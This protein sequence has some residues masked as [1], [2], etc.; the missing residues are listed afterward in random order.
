[1]QDVM[2]MDIPICDVVFMTQKC[3]VMINDVYTYV[4]TSIWMRCR[5]F[6][7]I[8]LCMCMRYKKIMI[9]IEWNIEYNDMFVELKCMI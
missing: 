4:F 1:M 3:D 9:Y 6:T 5:W 7:S 2:D 8:C